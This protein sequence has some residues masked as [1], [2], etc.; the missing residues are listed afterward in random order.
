MLQRVVASNA[1]A[2]DAWFYFEIEPAYDALREDPRFIELLTAVRAQ[3][4]AERRELERLRA[5]GL[6]PDRGNELDGS[7]ATRTADAVGS[8]DYGSSVSANTA[9]ARGRYP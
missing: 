6:V 9:S 1:G 5:A 8:P 3:S 2:T 4:E 7:P